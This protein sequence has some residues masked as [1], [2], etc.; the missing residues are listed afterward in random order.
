[1]QIDEGIA[2]R[3]SAGQK[4]RLKERLRAKRKLLK[5][6]IDPA[7]QGLH[8]VPS[9]SVC[10]R[11][12]PSVLMDVPHGASP[13]PSTLPLQQMP[14]QCAVALQCQERGVLKEFLKGGTSLR[15]ERARWGYASHPRGCGRQAR[16]RSV[17]AVS[18]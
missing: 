7:A 16:W 10:H 8:I 2:A 6:P 15:S 18:V 17:R 9:I 4:R 3:G 13:T 14:Y 12:S 1:M 5:D 11:I